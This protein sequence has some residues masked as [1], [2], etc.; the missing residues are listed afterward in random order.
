MPAYKCRKLREA[1]ITDP[2]GTQFTWSRALA[3]RQ[4]LARP[5]QIKRILM[6]E[7]KGRRHCRTFLRAVPEYVVIEITTVH[8]DFL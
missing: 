3:P 6:V 4:F 5:C 8:A 2:G 7:K 1:N